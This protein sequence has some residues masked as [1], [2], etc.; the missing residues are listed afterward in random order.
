MDQMLRLDRGLGWLGDGQGRIFEPA[1]RAWREE[2]RAVGGEP[3]DLREAVRWLQ[4]DSGR[5]CRVPIGVIGPRE[6]SPPQ[7]GA[8][9]HLGAE[10]AGLGLTVVCGGRQGVMEAVCQGVA[11]SGGLAVGVLPGDDWTAA[12]PYVAIPIATGI[13]EARNAII[14]RASLCLV[15]VGGSHGTISEIALGLQFG[16]PVFGLEE[17]PEVPGLV[18][19]S[20]VDAAVRAVARVVLALPDAGRPA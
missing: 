4:R 3:V 20:D 6:P 15:A 1:T 10:L 12:N 7:V 17:A 14:A 16:R 5:P 13:G 18:R 11:E 2:A 19:L 9:R 8:A